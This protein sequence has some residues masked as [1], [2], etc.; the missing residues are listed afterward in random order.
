MSSQ[1][2][3]LQSPG[4]GVKFGSLGMVV[5]D[6]LRFPRKGPLLDVMGGSGSYGMGDSINLHYEANVN[7]SSNVKSAALR[8]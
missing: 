2:S 4:L 3:D 5:L 7:A 6:E 1:L 8:Q